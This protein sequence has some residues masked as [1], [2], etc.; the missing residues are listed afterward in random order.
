MKA[1]NTETLFDLETK[2]CPN[3]ELI[4]PQTIN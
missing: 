1:I 3:I 2:I 4:N